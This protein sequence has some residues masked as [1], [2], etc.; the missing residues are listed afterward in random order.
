MLSFQARI[1]KD[2][3]LQ[4]LAVF[5]IL[6]SVVTSTQ[7]LGHI[8]GM[9]DSSSSFLVPFQLFLYLIP[10]VAVI[11]LPLSFL[12]ASITI[13][14]RMDDNWESI[15]LAAAGFRPM[16]I[17]A[18]IAWLALFLSAFIL[19]I[20]VYLEP[21][22]NKSERDKMVLFKVDALKLLASNGVLQRVQPGLYMRGGQLLPDGDIEDVFILDRRNETDE[23]TFIAERARIL[24]DDDRILLR[25]VNGTIQH[26]NLNEEGGYTIQF[27]EYTANSEIVFEK[28]DDIDYQPRQ[29][30]TSTLLRAYTS[31]GQDAAFNRDVQQELTRRFSDWLYPLVY[32]G[33]VFFLVFGLKFSRKGR[34]WRLPIATFGG[35]MVRAIGLILLGSS[36]VDIVSAGLSL[37]VPVGV[38]L[39]LT[40]LALITEER[41]PKSPPV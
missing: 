39:T 36:G 9:I 14:D 18:P 7:V 26:R 35:A 10:T 37:A 38:A 15:V 28:S 12:I 25:L 40:L 20:S 1:A 30:P 4:T 16:T 24:A 8:F 5:L 6:G 23:V 19:F 32:F 22:A 27:G 17:I 11:V 3:V 2:V 13:F 21:M 41:P 31:P 29:M 34:R 33:V